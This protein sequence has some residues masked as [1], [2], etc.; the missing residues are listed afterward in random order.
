MGPLLCRI[1]EQETKL[2]AKGKVHLNEI[3]VTMRKNVYQS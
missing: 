2:E 3:S 1:S